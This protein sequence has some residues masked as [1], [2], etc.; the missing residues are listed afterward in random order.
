MD[1]LG[2]THEHR[3]RLYELNKLC[4]QDIPGRAPFYTWEEYRLARLEVP[5]Y[6]PAGVVV[7]LNGGDWIGLSALSDWPDKGFMFAEMTGV[8][9]EFRRRGLAIAMKILG[10]RFAKALGVDRILTLHAAENEAP[11]LLNLSLG[12][13]PAEWTNLSGD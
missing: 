12:F 3:K 11:I 4:S 1:L 8:V 2:D 13:Q 9:R 6:N 10:I 5:R 7:A